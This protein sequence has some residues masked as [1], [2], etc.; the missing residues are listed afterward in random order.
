MSARFGNAAA[1]LTAYIDS[2]G[3]NESTIISLHNPLAHLGFI[4]V[5]A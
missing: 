1:E 2:L 4:S 5:P 3:G